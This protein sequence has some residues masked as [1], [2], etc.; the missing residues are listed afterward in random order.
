MVAVTPL[1][2]GGKTVSAVVLKVGRLAGT[3]D[4]PLPGYMTPGASGLDLVAANPQPVVLAPGARATIPTGLLLQVP[5]G[6]EGQI[7]PRSGLA[8]KAGVT[9][10]NSPGTVDSDY[11]GEVKIILVN[12]GDRDFVVSRG[13]RVAQ[14]VISPAVKAE[15]SVAVRL[16][17]SV[18][19]EGG[20]G[21][22]GGFDGARNE[23]SPT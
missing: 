16:E 9:V 8:A 15:I 5:A 4:L 18:R 22:T 14:L 6:F 23:R 1:D 12:L 3:E 21:H 20:F 11:R 17:D 7:R 19:G 13:D 10:L 2:L